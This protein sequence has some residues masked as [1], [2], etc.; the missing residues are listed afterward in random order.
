MI[1]MV[2]MAMMMMMIPI[3]RNGLIAAGDGE[4][5]PWGNEVYR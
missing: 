3:M 2:M 4:G 1:M 5:G